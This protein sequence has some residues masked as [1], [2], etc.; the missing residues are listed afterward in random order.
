[1]DFVIRRA[2]ESICEFRSSNHELHPIAVNLS[3]V[4]FRRGGVADR[5]RAITSEYGVPPELIEIE[6]TERY[7][8]DQDYES[9]TELEKLRA[10]GHSICVDDFG[11]GYSS[12]SYMKRLP[13][14]IIKIDRSF[15]QSIP[16]DQNDIEISQ[17]IISLSH[18]LGYKVVAEGVET[19][20][21]LEFLIE[22]S[23]DYAQGYYF[24]KPVPIDGYQ[25]RVIEVNEKLAIEGGWT[26][27]LRALRI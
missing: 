11:T 5:L 9:E 7:M 26:M 25:D 12:L 4:E 18:S 13:L 19:P 27:R 17:A 10:L 23:C 6:I 20:E 1:G 3:S 15:I 21:Q 14:N 24:S 2:C 8:L 22:R 16:F